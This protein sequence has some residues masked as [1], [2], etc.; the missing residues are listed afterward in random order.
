MLD[1]ETP[2]PG[3]IRT[4]QPDEIDDLSISSSSTL[5][6]V[7]DSPNKLRCYSVDKRRKKIELVDSVD[8]LAKVQAVQMTASYL[9]YVE[10]DAGYG[11]RLIARD[12][13]THKQVAAYSNLSYGYYLSYIPS[14]QLVLAAD[15]FQ[16]HVLHPNLKPETIL[17]VEGSIFGMDLDDSQ[18]VLV[19]EIDNG[20]SGFVNFDFSGTDIVKRGTYSSPKDAAVLAVMDGVVLLRTGEI[21]ISIVDN[22]D[23]EN[24]KIINV[25]T[26]PTNSA[27]ELIFSKI[28]FDQ[29]KNAYI[30]SYNQSDSSALFRIYKF[31]F[32]DPH[33]PVQKKIF[34]VPSYLSLLEVKEEDLLLLLN[35]DEMGGKR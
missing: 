35:V 9:Y 5:Y 13:T 23:L 18:K 22:S 2:T 8:D 32:Q 4:I 3:Y 19:V 28:S 6:T 27:E 1:T 31:S 10:G 12:V 21:E 15:E 7:E 11:V 26:L 14:K 33:D 17:E 16:I 29:D 30:P 25:Y 34:K 24:P 20:A